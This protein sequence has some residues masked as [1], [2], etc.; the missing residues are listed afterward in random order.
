MVY[1]D[2]LSVCVYDSLW[3]DRIVALSERKVRASQGRM[4]PNRK[5][6][7]ERK[8]PQKIYRPAARGKGEK[9]R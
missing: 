9:V 8:V 4:F 6:R 2:K 5:V 7:N 3:G 1:I